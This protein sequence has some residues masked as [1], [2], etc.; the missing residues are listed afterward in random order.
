ML[1]YRDGSSPSTHELLL[2]YS[3]ELRGRRIFTSSISWLFTFL[4]FFYCGQLQVLWPEIA[5]VYFLYSNKNKFTNSE[6]FLSQL[7]YQRVFLQYV[8]GYHWGNCIILHLESPQYNNNRVRESAYWSVY[9]SIHRF[10]FYPLGLMCLFVVW[11]ASFCS[12]A[13]SSQWSRLRL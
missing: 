9:S 6:V 13:C 5:F 11:F 3:L 10:C 8:V 1:C 7:N 2:D 12:S 4:R